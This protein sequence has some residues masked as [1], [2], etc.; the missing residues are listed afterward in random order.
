MDAMEPAGRCLVWFV[1]IAG[2]GLLALGFGLGWI[3][4]RFIG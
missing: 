2:A 3:V 4:R 1:I